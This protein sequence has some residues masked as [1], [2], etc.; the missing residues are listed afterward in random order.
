MPWCNPDRV[1]KGRVVYPLTPDGG[2]HRVMPV[3]VAWISLEIGMGVRLKSRPYP[4][5][6]SMPKA[7]STPTSTPEPALSL[8]YEAAL[9]ELEQLIARLDAGQLP[10]DQL[11]QQYQRGAQLLN[12]C[13]EQLKAVEDQIKVMDNGQ[14]TPW[15]A[16]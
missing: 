15:T 12:H 4:M 3:S 11:L 10:L 7:R 16:S 8:S 2:Q 5:P 9:S 14:L 6:P 13:K 1:K